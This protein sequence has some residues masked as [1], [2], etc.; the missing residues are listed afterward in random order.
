MLIQRYVLELPFKAYCLSLSRAYEIRCSSQ[1]ECGGRRLSLQPAKL[2]SAD[3]TEFRQP[4]GT[5]N[6]DKDILSAAFGLCE[7]ASKLYPE[8]QVVLVGL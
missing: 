5:F 3:E 7:C 4:F 1:T 2:S 8:M 6:G